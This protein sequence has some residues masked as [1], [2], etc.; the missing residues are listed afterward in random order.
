MFR[1]YLIRMVSALLKGELQINHISKSIYKRSNLHMTMRIFPNAII[2]N[3]FQFLVIFAHNEKY[4]S[5]PQSSLY[6]WEML[7][8][9]HQSIIVTATLYEQIWQLGVTQY[10]WCAHN[11]SVKVP[12]KLHLILYFKHKDFLYNMLR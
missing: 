3:V 7:T 9:N 1:F 4:N 6:R 12:W 5:T 8:T 2:K 11:Q 10:I